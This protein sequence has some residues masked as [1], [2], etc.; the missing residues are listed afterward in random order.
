MR[1]E[2]VLRRE[3]GPG[4]PG[5]AGKTFG[6]DHQDGKNLMPILDEYIDLACASLYVSLLRLLSVPRRATSTRPT[7][8]RN[9]KK[10]IPCPKT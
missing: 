4:R 3:E 10:K 1:D 9:V 5:R 6:H 8:R 7:L 2:E